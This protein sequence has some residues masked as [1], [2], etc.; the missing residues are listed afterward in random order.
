MMAN[1]VEAIAAALIRCKFLQRIRLASRRLKWAQSKRYQCVLHK[2]LRVD[3]VWIDPYQVKH[4]KRARGRSMKKSTEVLTVSVASQVPPSQTLLLLHR[5]S[6]AGIALLTL[7]LGMFTATCERAQTQGVSEQGTTATM[8]LTNALTAMGGQIAWSQIVDTTV[9][10]NC[11]STS[12]KANGTESGM[13]FRWI[14]AK[15]EF[16]YESGTAG[17]ISALLSGHGKPIDAGLTGA[18][19]LSY[20]TAALLKPF[21]L[22]GLVLFTVLNDPQYRASVIG[23]ET[24]SGNSTIHLR[25]VH[26]LA[27]GPESGSS[28]DW[29]FDPSTNLPLKVTYMAPGQTVQAYMP[30]T[31][32]FSQWSTEA[33]GLIVPHQLEESMELDTSLATCAVLAFKTNTQPNAS[34]FD[35]P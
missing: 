32:S 33:G 2:Q 15:E 1:S 8:V 5:R 20:E 31:Y 3:S 24:V 29:W 7:L 14:T 10:G 23:Q 21:H 12:T 16:R 22:P 28:Q 17:Q 35:A 11:T 4:S 19:S 18:L 27:R 25:V 13:P 34:L 9:T 26:R 6:G 30:I